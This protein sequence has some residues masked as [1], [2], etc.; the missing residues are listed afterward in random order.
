[1]TSQL[2]TSDIFDSW[3]VRVVRGMEVMWLLAVFLVPLAFVTP[4]L[5]GNGYDIP[6][7]TLY[8]GLVGLIGALWVIEL[9]L[10]L[11]RDRYHLEG[12]WTGARQRLFTH[13]ARW[14]LLAAGGVVA[15]NLA[16]TILSSSV[17]VSLWGAEPALD[18]YSFYNSLSHF[19]LFAAVAT[20]LK[21]TIQLWRLL[22]AIVGSGIVV[23]LY[24]NLQHFGLDPFGIAIVTDRVISSLGNPI[25]AA[26]FLLMVV[27]IALLIPLVTRGSPISGRATALG[28]AALA[29]V[30][31]AMAFTQARGPWIG[32][33]ATL[34]GF[35]CLV[36]VA[37]GRRSTVHA[38]V[39]L[40]GAIGITWAVVTFVPTLNPTPNPKH[41]ALPTALTPRAISIVSELGAAFTSPESAGGSA[42]AA[43]SRQGDFGPSSMRARLLL[44][45]GAGR[46]VLDRPRFE[47]D[48]KPLLPSL[49]LFGYGPEFFQY[50]FPLV[51]PLALT[52]RQHN[53]IYRGA[54]DA[55]SNLVHRA[56][57]LGFFGL[58][59]YLFLLAALTATG[60]GLLMGRHALTD[61]NHR[62]VMAAVLASLGGRTVEQVVGIPRL[63]DEALFWTLLAV[64][65]GL[66]GLTRSAPLPQHPRPVPAS[67]APVPH[68]RASIDAFWTV[69]I[70]SLA[71][72]S[73]AAM[74]WVTMVK[75]PYYFLAEIKAVAATHS[76]EEG[77]LQRA[78]RRVDEAIAL[79]PDVGRYH[80]QRAKILDQ[81][82]RMTSDEREWSRLAQEAYWSNQRATYAN[83]FDIYN[84][85]H[86]S[87]S[88]LTLAQ[89]GQ[90]ERAQEAIE[91]NRRLT[92][93]LPRYWLAHYLLGRAYDTLGH[94]GLAIGPYDEA[95]LYYPRSPF[96][97]QQRGIA[98]SALGQYE[99]AIEDYGQ[100]IRLSWQF[101]SVYN[102]RGIAFYEMGRLLEAKEDFDEAI[103]LEPG[104][105]I[106][107]YNRSLAHTLL[108]MDSEAESDAQRAANLGFDPALIEQ[109]IGDLKAVR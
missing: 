76:S 33:A 74:L 87:D 14:V 21:T 66:P 68:F 91:E 98:H 64:V 67:N 84:R 97:Y 19:V 71:L 62:L 80:V 81:A 96:L 39:V 40:F 59:S 49:H 2:E 41:L 107:Y 27:P 104:F 101:S 108:E 52:D 48:E 47:F 82:R 36:W 63:P 28:I 15:S 88:A 9:G 50:L 16:S 65:V 72:V 92:V 26:A 34:T 1:M 35:L 103:H 22:G 54:R 3:V 10:K 106:A 79:A 56:V 57:E 6:K 75:N 55:H 44:W 90:P 83:P 12:L 94:P 99:R 13:P 78:M 95:I 17:S 11:S 105:A 58:A 7:V 69:S 61:T 53:S 24:G 25:S 31:L 32:L 4:S 37:S 60:I 30:L 45:Q 89:L 5:M 100:A 42:V 70:L 86:F 102:R 43:D 29:I 109:S 18:G 23:G 8:R 46:L 38:I 20:H 93:A 51:R 85:L 73:A 77:E